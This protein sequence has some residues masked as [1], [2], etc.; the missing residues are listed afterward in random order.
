M[1]GNCSLTQIQLHQHKYKAIFFP[2]IHSDPTAVATLI[3]PLAVHL[4]LASIK[5]FVTETVAFIAIFSRF[6]KRIGI[7]ESKL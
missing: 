7:T 6:V 1:E 2:L 5:L 3:Y 4:D